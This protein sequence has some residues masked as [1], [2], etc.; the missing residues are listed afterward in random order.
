MK[1]KGAALQAAPSLDA[2]QSRGRTRPHH[3]H[4][5]NPMIRP[6][7]QGYT[8]GKSEGFRGYPK[9]EGLLPSVEESGPCPCAM[10]LRYLSKRQVRSFRKL[11]VR[12]SYWLAEPIFWCG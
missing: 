3:D 12:P 6:E 11:K 7:Q 2:S 1:R 10:K 9:L 4:A 8:P 5:A